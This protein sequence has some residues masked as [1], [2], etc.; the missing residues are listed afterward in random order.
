[1]ALPKVEDARKLSDQEL[2]DE[3]VAA[4][5]RLFE[6]RFQQATRQLEKQ[7]HQFKHTRHWIAQLMT[8]QQERALAAVKSGTAE[9]SSELSTEAVSK[10]E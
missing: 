10:D 8:V 7:T 2:S 5:K 3:I 6:L 4:K 9:A 1:M